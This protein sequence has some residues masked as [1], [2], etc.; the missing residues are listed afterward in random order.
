[1]RFMLKRESLD[2][3]RY[4]DV[5]Q[6]KELHSDDLNVEGGLRSVRCSRLGHN[7]ELSHS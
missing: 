6:N 1:V 5:L 3:E 2:L 4:S 7:A